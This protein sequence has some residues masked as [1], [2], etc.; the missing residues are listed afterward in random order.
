MVKPGGWPGWYMTARSSVPSSS[1][2]IITAGRLALAEMAMSGMLSRSQDIHLRRK[3]SHS[4]AG[5]PT[6]RWSRCW[7]AS[8]TSSGAGCHTRT[9]ASACFWNCSPAPV[10]AAP[11]LERSNS[12]RPNSSSSTRMRAL[13][14]DCVMLS[15]R[16]ASMKLP[17]SATIRNVRASAMS[18]VRLRLVASAR[19]CREIYLS[20]TSIGINGKK[21]LATREKIFTLT[22]PGRDSGDCKEG[23]YNEGE[24]G[25]EDREE[26]DGE[27]EEEV[28]TE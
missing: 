4:A 18:I 21:R 28:K 27:E 24:E 3:P 11:L 12:G 17:V 19:V 23:H 8:P 6:A 1:R 26:E 9:S 20:E 13:T 7:P 22:G 15:L 25:E 2:W 10:S 5:A 16:A 14:V